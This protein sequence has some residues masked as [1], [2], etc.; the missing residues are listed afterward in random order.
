MINVVSGL[1]YFDLVED[2]LQLMNRVVPSSSF[3]LR[4]KPISFSR[5]TMMTAPSHGRK[6]PSG[7]AG[8]LIK[9][10]PGGY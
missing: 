7:G 8:S 9:P 4:D 2:E 5:P 10:N 1:T 3:L 6:G